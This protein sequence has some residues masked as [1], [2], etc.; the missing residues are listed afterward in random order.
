MTMK[1]IFIYILIAGLSLG[2]SSC[3]KFFDNMDSCT[4]RNAPSREAHTSAI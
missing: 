3:D 1:K 4:A 2:L